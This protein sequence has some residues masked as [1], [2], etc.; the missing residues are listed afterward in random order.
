[1]KQWEAFCSVFVG[2]SNVTYQ[3]LASSGWEWYGTSASDSE[4]TFDR[5]KKALNAP[6]PDASKFTCG[7]WCH[8][9]DYRLPNDETK[10]PPTDAYC[11]CCYHVESG[12]IIIEDCKSLQYISAGS[13]HLGSQPPP[14]LDRLSDVMALE[15]I[16]QADARVRLYADRLNHVFVA[17]ITNEE[18]VHMIK[19]ILERVCR[20]DHRSALS[21]SVYQKVTVEMDT[22]EGKALLGTPSGFMLAVMLLQHRARLGLKTFRR[23]QVC[24]D[25][26]FD[27]YSTPD[28]LFEIEDVVPC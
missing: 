11:C 27:A 26:Y 22:P 14:T 25:G 28:L 12:I 19:H 21:G 10:Y 15:Y 6:I 5:V 20:Q 4:M 17:H 8:D 13:V 23:V 7:M 3:H 24:Y 9:N 1:M 18:S 16:H 2:Q